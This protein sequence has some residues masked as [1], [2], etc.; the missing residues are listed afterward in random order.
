MK[1]VI[2]SWALAA[3]LAMSQSVAL[4]QSE[5]LRLPISL[6]SAEIVDPVPAGGGL[7][8]GNTVIIT[9][10]ASGFMA[11]LHHRMPV[12]VRPELAD[13]WFGGDE[14]ALAAAI[15]STPQLQAWPVDRAVN[16][17]RHEGDGLV[18]AQGVPLQG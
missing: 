1:P 2:F 13:R 16:N 9:T 12:I 8:N 10:A 3:A 18:E 14:D 7:I 4:A 5:S 11:S 6:A 17:P 15:A